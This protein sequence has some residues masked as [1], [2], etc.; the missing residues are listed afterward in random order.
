MFVQSPAKGWQRKFLCMYIHC[1]KFFAVPWWTGELNEKHW[2]FHAAVVFAAIPK[3]GPSESG[4]GQD[5]CLDL[6]ESDHHLPRQAC[7]CI[8]VWVFIVQKQV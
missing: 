5:T 7:S 2:V 4:C 8:V 1:G 6:V 3:T